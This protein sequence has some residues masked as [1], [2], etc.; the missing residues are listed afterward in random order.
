MASTFWGVYDS[1]MKIKSSSFGPNMSRHSQGVPYDLLDVHI[2][3][4]S[5]GSWSENNTCCVFLSPGRTPTR[6]KVFILV[7]MDKEIFLPFLLHL[8]TLFYDWIPT[9]WKFSPVFIS[10]FP[11]P[12]STFASSPWVVVIAGSVKKT[13]FLHDYFCFTSSYCEV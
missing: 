8:L 12:F 1:D 4:S 11:S 3:E 9:F 10:P 13:Q 2:V 6:P 5:T 7:K